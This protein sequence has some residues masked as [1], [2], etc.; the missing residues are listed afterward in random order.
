LLKYLNHNSMTFF[1]SLIVFFILTFCLDLSGQNLIG[2]KEKDIRQYMQDKQKN[3]SFQNMIY[4]ST[5]KYLKYQDMNETQT[6]LFFLTT[7]SVCKSIRLVCDKSLESDKIKE[8]NSAY[9][10]SGNN[11]WSEIRNGKKYIIELKEEEWS[12]NVTYSLN[13]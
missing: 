6:L 8:L 10:I 5:F 13:Q 12:Y 7:D 3:F 4:N 11:V 2:Y 9:T 1:R